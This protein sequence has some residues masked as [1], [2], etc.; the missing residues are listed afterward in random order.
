M[1]SLGG[2]MHSGECHSSCT[3][4]QHVIKQ[5]ILNLYIHLLILI[6]FCVQSTSGGCFDWN[7]VVKFCS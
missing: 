5:V 2:G 4:I 1:S 7:V 6:Y 3:C